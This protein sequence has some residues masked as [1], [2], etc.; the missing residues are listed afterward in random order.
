MPTSLPEHVP[1]AFLWTE[2][3]DVWSVSLEPVWAEFVGAP[4][5][6][7]PVPLLDAFP[8]TLWL[9]ADG[10]G[11]CMAHVAHLVSCQINHYQYLFLLRLLERVAE[12]DEYLGSSD[13]P[14]MMAFE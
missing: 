5:C 6:P 7:R 12:I 10:G 8:L 13:A 11:G 3:R 9:T 14:V 1:H 2:A 4:A